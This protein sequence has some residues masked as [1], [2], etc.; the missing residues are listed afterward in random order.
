MIFV[1][2][3]FRSVT[4]DVLYVLSEL[5]DQEKS[6]RKSLT[7][8]HCNRLDGAN[9]RNFNLSARFYTAG[10]PPRYYA[11]GDLKLTPE[12]KIVLLDLR[13]GER[14]GDERRQRRFRLFFAR[15]TQS[16]YDRPAKR[17]LCTRRDG[18]NLLTDTVPLNA[19]SRFQAICGGSISFSEKSSSRSAQFISELNSEV[20]GGN[21]PDRYESDV[22]SEDRFKP[23]KL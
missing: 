14:L 7:S 3:N 10:Y 15:T 23:P 20:P 4:E 5:L 13:V 16:C 21:V 19:M 1:Y 18:F 6:Y 17:Y 11:K 9:S 8:E 12:G 22:S 2:T